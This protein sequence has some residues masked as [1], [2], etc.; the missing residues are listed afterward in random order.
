[1]SVPKSTCFHLALS[2]LVSLNTPCLENGATHSGLYL[3]TSFNKQDSR[4]AHMPIGWYDLG[5]LHSGSPRF[6]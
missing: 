1:M 2:C 6:P 3:S 5:N 4:H